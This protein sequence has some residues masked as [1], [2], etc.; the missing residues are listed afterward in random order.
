MTYVIAAILAIL[1][2]L[3]AWIYSLVRQNKSLKEA[4]VN[5]DLVNKNKEWSD[6]IK[7]IED[8]IKESEKDYEEAKRNF[9][10]DSGNPPSGAV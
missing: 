7:G 5:A 1:S 6:K 4:A 2:G 10:D 9:F 3:S 8:R